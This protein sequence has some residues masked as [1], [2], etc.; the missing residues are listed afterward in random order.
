M[1]LQMGFILFAADTAVPF[2]QNTINCLMKIMP[3]METLSF[4][5]IIILLY[6]FKHILFLLQWLNVK[7]SC[8]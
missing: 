3:L 5:H 6:M 1:T 2:M 8:R 7:S 4:F